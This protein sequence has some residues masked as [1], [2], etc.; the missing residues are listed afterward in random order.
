[1]QAEWGKGEKGRKTGV[2]ERNTGSYKENYDCGKLF[3]IAGAG[4]KI[5]E[6]FKAKKKPKR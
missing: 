4:N 6:G 5:W 2:R 1:M 3:W